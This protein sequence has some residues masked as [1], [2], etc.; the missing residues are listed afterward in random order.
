MKARIPPFKSI[1][2]F[3][4][5]ARS[6]SFT[7]AA[8]TLN[9]TVPAVSRRIQTL[10]MDLGV[11][12]FQRTHRSLK[13]T[14]AGEVYVSRLAPAIEGLQRASDCIRTKAGRRSVKVS[15]PASLAANWLVPRLHRFRAEHEDI[16]FE[17]EST[18][19]TTDFDEKGDVDLAIWLGTGNWP[20]VRT[21]RLLDVEAS[22]VCRAELLAEDAGLRT[23]DDVVKFP[24]LGIMHQ[25]DLW[26]EWL[27]SAG[28][29]RPERVSHAFDN[30][31]LLYRAAASGLGIALG[32]DVI[33]RPYLDDGQ[34]VLPFNRWCKLTK[35][36]YVVCRSADWTRRP[37]STFRE[38]L[39][40]EAEAG[41]P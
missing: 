10:E 37:V 9:L 32:I 27:R 6:L 40:T 3:V 24:L 21:E 20:G 7:A 12:L 34:L 1:E 38:W 29:K 17:L 22:P 41:N 4:V 14:D 28:I 13:L 36:Y 15:L 31:H 8:S 19:G 25:H 11:A 33:V 16:N 26:A 2:A 30:F 23:E 39:M 18:N 35:G 5:A